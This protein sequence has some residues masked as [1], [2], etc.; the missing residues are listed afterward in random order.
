MIHAQR[1]IALTE[2]FGGLP[3]AQKADLVT[4]LLNQSPN[5]FFQPWFLGGKK[6]KYE[7]G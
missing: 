7:A 4:M 5:L 2:G 6:T 3:A 1:R